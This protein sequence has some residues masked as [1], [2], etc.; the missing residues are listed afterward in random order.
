MQ[1]NMRTGHRISHANCTRNMLDAGV[2]RI[3][4]THQRQQQTHQTVGHV[5]GCTPN[6][7]QMWN[8]PP[9]LYSNDSAMGRA[10]R[11]TQKFICR[12]FVCRIPVCAN[13]RGRLNMWRRRCQSHGSATCGAAVLSRRVRVCV[14]H[15]RLRRWQCDGT[16]APT[17]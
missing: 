10:V 4:A 6:R 13:A 12:N 14:S 11:P 7:T 1:N 3:N 5:Q 16:P 15:S 2:H 17:S 8:T 9:H